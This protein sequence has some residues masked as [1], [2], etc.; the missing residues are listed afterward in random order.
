MIMENKI[1]VAGLLKDC[2]EGME[3]DCTMYI[4]VTFIAVENTGSYPIKLL[5]GSMKL[6]LTK[7]GCYSNTDDAKCVIFPKGKTTWE[8]FMPPCE[9]KDGDILA[10]TNGKF[11]AIIKK[12]G[13]KCYVCCHTNNT[14]F[15]IDSCGWF[16]RFATEEEKQKLFDAIKA[17]GYR[18]DEET[19]TL[20]KLVEPKF[21]VGDIIVNIYRKHLNSDSRGWKIYQI[22]NDK[23][24]FTDGSYI[25]IQDQNNWELVPTNSTLPLLTPFV[26]VLV[27]DTNDCVWKADFYSHCEDNS[28]YSHVCTGAGYHQCI[29]YNEETAN[30]IG[31]TNDCPD[32]YKTWKD[33]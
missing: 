25:H 2:P 33:E 14:F 29:P 26:K 20:E 32:K 10:T 16:D 21:K 19:K 12:N 17:N 28:H 24:I 6:N 1:N 3:L 8:G 9:F 15:E 13:G 30:L 23:Y 31:T 27:R 18:W 5:A 7:S 11:I 4:N 22:E